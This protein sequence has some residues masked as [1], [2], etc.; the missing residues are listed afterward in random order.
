[1]ATIGEINCSHKRPRW[2]DLADSSTEQLPEPPQSLCGPVSRLDRNKRPRWADLQDS[3]TE[4]LPELADPLRRTISMSHNLG[5]ESVQMAD[6]ESMDGLRRA[7]SHTMSEVRKTGALSIDEENA[8]EQVSVGDPWEPGFAASESRQKDWHTGKR[9]RRERSRIFSRG[10]N[11]AN[12]QPDASSGNAKVKSKGSGFVQQ[13]LTPKA[14][15][16]S[17][18]KTDSEPAEVAPCL[19]VSDEEWQRR[20][21]KR[22]AIVASTKELPAYRVA[23]AQRELRRAQGALSRSPSAPRTPDPHDRGI[24]KRTWEKVIADWRCYL[25][26][27]ESEDAVQQP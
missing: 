18:E 2:A 21:E 5:D 19:N 3:S 25:K 4:Q 6:S 13:R 8:G 26:N 22:C 15:A 1:M 9:I 27:A 14:K 23:L 11:T 17:V 7:L 10:N 24:S 20:V 12:L 16:K